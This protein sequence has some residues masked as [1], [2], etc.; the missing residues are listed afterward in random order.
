M[1]SNGANMNIAW[2]HISVIYN[3]LLPCSLLYA[4]N[5]ST[6]TGRWITYQISHYKSAQKFI[7]DNFFNCKHD[8]CS[9]KYQH[10]ISA[11][12]QISFKWNQDSLQI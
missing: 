3:K 2:P 10:Y 7:P 5:I 4:G 8:C 9:Q 11:W 6:T 12:T 1:N